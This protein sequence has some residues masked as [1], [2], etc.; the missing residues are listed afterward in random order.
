VTDAADIASLKD[1]ACAHID[2]L[3]EQL[4]AVSH[5]IHA[6]PELGFE[7]RHAHRVLTEAIARY[8]PGAALEPHACGLETAFLAHAGPAGPTVGVVCEYD[9]LP[10]LGHA[11]GHNI[12]AAAGLG[13]GLALAA[14]ADEVG[15][16]VKILGTPAEEGGGGKVMMIDAG[17]FDDVDVALMVHPAGVD[18]ARMSTLAI[19]RCRAR[20]RGRAAHA[21]A[22]P[23]KGVNALDGAVLGYNAIAALRQHIADE[24]RI[25][26]VFIAGGDKP[27]IVPSHAETEWYV[28]S[29]TMEGLRLLMDRVTRCLEG[30]ATAAGCA[31]EIEW[32]DPCYAEMVDN[33]PLA[34]CYVA[35]AAALGRA[36]QM[37][38]PHTAVRGSTDM[39]NVS[40][41]VP[42][43]HPMI[44]VAPDD[45]AI[46]TE[47]F[48]LCAVSSAGDRGV[49]DG[50]KAMAMT[51]IDV[52]LVPSVLES[53]TAAAAVRPNR[54]PRA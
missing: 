50:A 30:G 31:V 53:I 49:I 6:E 7:E 10:G 29:P 43:I 54:S 38:T 34:D 3:A 28:R 51:A 8:A 35:N 40:H 46:H 39:G 23:D 21:A 25:H 13:A 33:E 4:I 12:I 16:R 2:A 26:G 15:H 20:Y 37:P 36:V 5:S 48:A 32:L 41:V 9:A 44:K 24:E 1:R 45:T 14:M 52:W 11:C 19:H 27:N 42:S 17:A 22:A 18:L 47:D